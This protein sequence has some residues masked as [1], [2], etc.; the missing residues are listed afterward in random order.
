MVVE[1]YTFVCI[2]IV[3]FSILSALY[4]LW[5]NEGPSS[6]QSDFDILVN[7]L[8]VASPLPNN[9]VT[10]GHVT[11]SQLWTSCWRGVHPL[12][13]LATRFFSL[14]SLVVLLSFDLHEYDATIF[15]YYTEYLI[16]LPSKFN[17]YYYISNY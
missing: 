17:Y 6:S 13:L 10:I 12:V 3:G 8:L 15:Y 14:L 7:T 5:I 1:W 11:T 9:R 16:F 2:C 4:V